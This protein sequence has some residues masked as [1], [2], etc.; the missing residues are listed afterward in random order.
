MAN[1]ALPI[2][3]YRTQILDAVATHQVVIIEADTGAGKSTQVPQYLLEAGH[4]LVV[5][6]PRKLAARTVAARVAEELGEEVGETVGAR[7]RDDHVMGPATRCL[8]VTDGLALVRELMG[9][10]D[11]SILVIDEVHEWNENI[12]VLVAWAKLQ[13]DS[14]ARFKLVLMSATLEAQR[15]S[16]HFNNAPVISV[17][18]RLFPVVERP[19]GRKMIEDVEA[20]LRDGRNVLVFQPGKTEIADLIADLRKT[21]VSAEILPLHGELTREEQAD[22]FRHYGRPKCVVATNVAQTSVTINDIDAVVD[23]G[24]E[25]RIELV[26]GVEG[27]YLR[28]ISRADSKQRKGRAG[29]TKPGIYIDH[30]KA[31]D[32]AEFPVAEIMR[33]RLDQTVLRLAVA[34]FDAE[35]LPF[36]HQP[37]TQEI[38][39]ARRLLRALG[40]MDAEGRVTQ[41]GYRVNKMPVSVMCARMVIEADE[42][43]VVDDVLTI[44]AILDTGE[45]TARKDQEGNDISHR[46]RAL[47]GTE[48]ESDV[49][50]Q[51]AVYN[52]ACKIPK[53]ELAKNGVHVRAFFQAKETRRHLADSLRGK[54]RV[55][56]TGN[57]AHILR[58]VCAGMV[59]H[60]YQYQ[61]GGYVNG[62]G[63]YREL[64]NESVVP[65]GSWIVG[66]PFD[67]EVK[68]KWGPRKLHLIRMATKVDPKT[69]AEIAPHLF[70]RK[71]GQNPRYDA[72]TDCVVSTTQTCFKSVVV[73][74]EEVPDQNHPTAARL[75]AS[76][77]AAKML[78]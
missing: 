44:A 60:L 75:F 62:D 58:A 76:W 71:T 19:A 70:E 7:T 32:R 9:H 34:G 6:Q 3:D 4:A 56:T 8:F 40:C 54:I 53:D 77:L 33:R 47:I 12:E 65:V 72:D 66:L 78:G 28:P 46:W 17:P 20:L 37:D 45:I 18:G 63:V 69:M 67:L 41:I 10:G 29:R 5:T 48:R 57:R 14:G 1:I 16:E 61:G 50:A 42:L 13:I 26:S 38:H 51:L 35:K 2:A 15:L 25:R 64:G 22:C 74:T 55:G 23:S 39:N 31:Y 49:M 68:G 52:R 73:A 59:D 43:G 21:G 36:F 24:M 27:L 30:C 11:H